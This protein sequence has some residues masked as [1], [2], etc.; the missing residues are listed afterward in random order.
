MANDKRK[1]GP[2]AKRLLSRFIARVAVP[3]GGGMESS[4][5][6]FADTEHRHRVLEVAMETLD[7]SI[8]LIRQAP[9]NPYGDDEEAIAAA[10]LDKLEAV[11]ENQR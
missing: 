5:R 9:D 4:L 11:R 8:A 1:L 7:A 6:F 2:N 3:P 10:I